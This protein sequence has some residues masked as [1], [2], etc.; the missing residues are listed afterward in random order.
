VAPIHA[1]KRSMALSG[2]VIT[3]NMEK[4]S[5]YA[6][7]PSKDVTEYMGNQFEATSLKIKTTQMNKYLSDFLNL[8]QPKYN[9]IRVVDTIDINETKFSQFSLTERM[10][11]KNLYPEEVEFMR[12]LLPTK[13]KFLPHPKYDWVSSYM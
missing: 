11:I 1:K 3:K 8:Y 7:V 9:R 5:V 12:W 10:Y 13:A 2:S 6:G 4:N